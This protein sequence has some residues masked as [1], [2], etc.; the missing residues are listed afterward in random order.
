MAVNLISIGN[1]GRLSRLTGVRERRYNKE[2]IH[3]KI[4]PEADRMDYKKSYALM[5]VLYL[6]GA[7][8]LARPC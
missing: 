7:V 5:W 4:I 1:C 2:K 8:L 3:A 6:A